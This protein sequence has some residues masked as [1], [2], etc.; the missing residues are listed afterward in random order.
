MVMVIAGLMPDVQGYQQATTE[1]NRQTE[2]VEKGEKFIVPD[3]A[4]AN[5]KIVF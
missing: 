1:A 5:L 2:Y 3:I 4:P